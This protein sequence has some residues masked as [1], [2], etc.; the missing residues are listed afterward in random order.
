MLLL[1]YIISSIL[2]SSRIFFVSHDGETMTVTYIMFLLYF[3]TCVT[4]TCGIIPLLLSKFKIKKE[5][6]KLKIK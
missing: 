5:I 3:V 6:R 4:V 2:E 1:Y